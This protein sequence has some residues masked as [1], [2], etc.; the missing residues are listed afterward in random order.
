MET[1]KQKTSLKTV[2]HHREGIYTSFKLELPGLTEVVQWIE[3]PR[4]QS[5]SAI[6]D[7]TS[8]VKPVGKTSLGRLVL[9]RSVPSNLL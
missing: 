2:N 5:S 8:P 9:S 6:S 7:V 1:E 3:Q 4:S